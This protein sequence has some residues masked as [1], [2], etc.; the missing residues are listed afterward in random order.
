VKLEKKEEPRLRRN[1]KRKKSED[2]TSFSF[3]NLDVE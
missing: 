2:H 3:Y 1:I